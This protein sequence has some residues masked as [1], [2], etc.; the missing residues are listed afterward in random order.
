VALHF[1]AY[2]FVRRIHRCGRHQRASVE[3]AL[4][5]WRF[6]GNGWI[7][8]DIEALKDTIL[9]LRGCKADHIETVP[10]TE[11]FRGEIVWQGD[12][13][14]FQIRGHLKAKRCYAWAHSAGK[15][16]QGE[17]YVTVLELPPVDSP[18]NAVKA[19]I[20]EDKKKKDQTR[21]SR[22]NEISVPP[23]NRDSALTLRPRRT[24]ARS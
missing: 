21:Y 24:P 18:Q 11:T 3:K 6:G 7:V 14:V 15:D 2:N 23:S 20:V 8:T 13:E 4:G 17:R 16:D 1:L 5:L 22:T 10:V 9:R 19:A 12:V